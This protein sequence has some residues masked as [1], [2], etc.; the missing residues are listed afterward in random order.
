MLISLG[1]LCL[2]CMGWGRSQDHVGLLKDEAVRKLH[3]RWADD[4]DAIF[5]PDGI[6]F[7]GPKG[8]EETEAEHVE[9]LAHNT[10]M[11]F[12]RTFKSPACPP[13]ILELWNTRKTC[14][15]YLPIGNLSCVV[16]W[17]A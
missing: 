6:K 15:F 4:S 14:F 7:I 16:E 12:Q 10:R 5:L 8:R 3:E 13:K 1:A 9:R 2:L 17:C 11:R